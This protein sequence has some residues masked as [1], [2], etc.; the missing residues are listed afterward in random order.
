MDIAPIES[1]SPSLV[2]RLVQCGHQEGLRRATPESIRSSLP[3]SDASALGT[4]AHAVLARVLKS[5]DSRISDDATLRQIWEDAIDTQYNRTDGIRPP[6]TWWRYNV[7]RRGT[8]RLAKQLVVDIERLQGTASVEQEV[9]SDDGT[10]WGR[11][12][13]V[14]RYPDG[15]AEIVDFKTGT[16]DSGPP[17]DGELRQLMIYGF[18]VDAVDC[19]VTRLKIARVDGET[20]SSAVTSSQLQSAAAEALRAVDQFNRALP[21]TTSLARPGDACTFCA[22][23]LGCDVAWTGR[24]P[25]SALEGRVDEAYVSRDLSVIS[26][27]TTNDNSIVRLV[28]VPLDVV[29]PPGSSIRAVRLGK[30][31][32]GQFQW[33]SGRSRIRVS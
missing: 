14:L 28:G 29:P 15:S 17:D 10:L 13:L 16:H 9:R 5:T 6:G 8:F 3:I 2:A 20:W 23:S 18:L 12:D 30:Q 7:V 27:R 21:D 25:A 22:Q 19:A 1:A 24:I 31:S 11:P 4:A 33:Q 26:V 32:P